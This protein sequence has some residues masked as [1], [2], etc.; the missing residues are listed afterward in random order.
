MLSLNSLSEGY[1]TVAIAFPDVQGRLLGRRIPARHFLDNPEQ[2]LSICTA[3]LAW[4]IS[5]GV[6]HVVPFAGHHTGWHDVY[7]RPALETLRPYPGVAGTAICIGDVYDEEGHL[8]EIAP[9]TILR[10][11]LERARKLGYTV[12]LASEL[13]FYLFQGDIRTARLKRFQGLEPTT[14]VRSD[15]SI[16]GQAVQEPFIQRIRREMETAGIPIY[17]CQAEYGLGQWEVNLEH[18]EAMEMCDRHAVYKSG[19]KELALQSGL[20]LTFM[21]KPIAADTGSSCHFHCSVRSGDNPIFAEAV[22]ARQ[23]ST[24]G[25]TFLGGLMSHLSE[26]ALF[27]APYVNS[28]KRHAGEDY[29]GGVIAWG[30]DNRTVTF[31]VL[32]AG[33]SLRL[34]HRY[35]G[36]DANP[37]LA[38]AAIIAAGLDGIENSLDPGASI[39]GNA[40]ERRDLRRAPASL[41]EAVESFAGSEFA[42]AAFGKE[43]IDHYVAHARGEWNG[44]LKTVTDWELDRAFELV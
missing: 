32:G 38:A 10:R 11:Q 43:V 9:R 30:N 17:A 34:E 16:V 5:E 6:P 21:A 27:Y 23:L 28:Y 25:K 14:I 44:Y 31:R 36:A 35:A 33:N 2:E 41:G 3:S 20:T 8:L 39:M 22:G 24:A 15:Y 37:Y 26:T 40:Y 18:A 4:D 19:V 13:E 7:V 29:G 42:S 12:L 1:H